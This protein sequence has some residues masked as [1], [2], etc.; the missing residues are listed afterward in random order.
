MVAV[1][2]PSIKIYAC[3]SLELNSVIMHTREASS[4]AVPQHTRGGVF[5]SIPAETI[6]R[7]FAP[8]LEGISF[9]NL[10]NDIELPEVQ[11]M[12]LAS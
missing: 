9:P 3:Q 10:D 12:R 7:F 4:V 5:S 1:F 8:L 11:R 2:S 6:K